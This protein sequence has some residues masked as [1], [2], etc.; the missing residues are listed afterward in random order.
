M[1]SICTILLLSI[2][3]F[4]PQHEQLNTPKAG[5]PFSNER[6][7]RPLA[8]GVPF[9]ME[10]SKHP[11]TGEIIPEEW[12]PIPD[13]E[14]LYEISN[15]GRVKS[16]QRIIIRSNGHPQTINERILSPGKL[17]ADHGHY[18]VV[19]LCDHGF[20]KTYLIHVMVA[21][22]FVPKI[23]NKTEVNHIDEVKSN[24]FYLNLEWC[25]HYE[26]NTYKKKNKT[27]RFYGVHWNSR[28]KGWRAIVVINGKAKYLGIYTSEEL[29]YSIVLE[30]QKKHGIVNKY[31]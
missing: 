17:H 22:L 26:N 15:Y 27:S 21:E 28:Q 14:G 11:I 29:A 18:L 24:N 19:M 30:T 5:A 16:L 7:D 31:A 1:S 20:E 9:V 10:L 13:Y 12:K 6:C 25:N 8:G 3:S 4:V 2:T 23:E